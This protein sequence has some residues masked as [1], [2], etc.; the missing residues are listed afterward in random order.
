MKVKVN[1]IS[2][3]TGIYNTIHAGI[4]Y[5]CDTCGAVYPWKGGLQHHMRI[6]HSGRHTYRKST[7]VILSG[8]SMDGIKAGPR[9]DQLTS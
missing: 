3:L 1:S 2:F 9:D 6:K 8:N 4:T 5:N 7:K